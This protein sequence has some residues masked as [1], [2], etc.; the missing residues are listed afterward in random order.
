MNWKIDFEIIREVISEWYLIPDAPKDEFDD[1]VYGIQS[2]LNKGLEEKEIVE[3]VLFQLKTNFG[4]EAQLNEV[5]L[6]IKEI[7]S[8]TNT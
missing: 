5:E 1:L 2:R 3:F 8:A 6:K 7:I 4:I